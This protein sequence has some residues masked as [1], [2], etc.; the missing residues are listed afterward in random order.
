[1]IQLCNLILALV[2]LM[3]LSDFSANSTVEGWYVVNDGVMGGLSEGAFSVHQEGYA[4]FEGDVS[5]E[6]NGGFTSVRHDF[7]TRSIKGKKV[8]KITLKGDGKNYQFRT[9][10]EGG[11]FQ[12]KYGFET[13]GEW[14]T[15]EIPLQEMTPTWRGRRPNVPNFSG[16]TIQQVGFLIANKK[17]ES[18][19][20]LIKKIWVE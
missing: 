13:S 7:E 4:V 11:R 15:I 8:M 3:V 20:L 19:K 18:F 17:N 2:S 14:E 6:N 12:F 5:L 16:K 10:E 1:M 9:R